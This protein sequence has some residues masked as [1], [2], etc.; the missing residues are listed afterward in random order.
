M[1]IIKVE[2][3]TGGTNAPTEKRE[4]TGEELDKWK[5]EHGYI[6]EEQNKPDTE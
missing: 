2:I 3:V 5:K 6:T 1:D 4:L